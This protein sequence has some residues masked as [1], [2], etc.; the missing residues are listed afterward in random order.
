MAEEDDEPDWRF[1]VDTM[2]PLCLPPRIQVL[3]VSPWLVGRAGRRGR[4]KKEEE[5]K[6]TGI[7]NTQ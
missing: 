7:R 4:R 1:L 3:F 5:R 6:G 2:F